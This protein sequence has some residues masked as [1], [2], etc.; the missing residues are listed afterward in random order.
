MGTPKVVISAETWSLHGNTWIYKH[1]DTNNYVFIFDFKFKAEKLENKLH[2][3]YIL[4]LFSSS[5]IIFYNCDI[6]VEELKFLE[7]E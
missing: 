4:K 3:L 7:E 1:K 2:I 6:D 5:I